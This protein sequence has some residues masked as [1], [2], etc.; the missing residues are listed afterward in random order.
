MGEEFTIKCA[1]TLSGSPAAVLV[2]TGTL[3]IM[4]CDQ[5]VLEIKHSAA[6]VLAK[7][8]V[9]IGAATDPADSEAWS[10]FVAAEPNAPDNAITVYDTQGTDQGRR[11]IDGSLSGMS[12]VQVRVRS[13][14]HSTGWLK[15]QKLQDMM[16]LEVLNQTV[17]IDQTNYRLNSVDKIGDVLA[18][19]KGPT[20][21]THKFTINA[22][23]SLIAV[24]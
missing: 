8:L 20:G 13:A 6:H 22:L 2:E 19:G 21:S 11:M 4:A 23:V 24:E 15:A 7:V 9:Q 5:P 14:N 17:T 1:A 16:A 18:I 12:G 10:V 3:R